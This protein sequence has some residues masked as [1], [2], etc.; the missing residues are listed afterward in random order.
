MKK[1]RQ[2]FFTKKS[3]DLTQI[4]TSYDN[5]SQSFA[6]YRLVIDH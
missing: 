3:S 1:Q 6:T 2:I 5:K 4:R